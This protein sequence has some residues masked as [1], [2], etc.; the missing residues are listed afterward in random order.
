[1]ERKIVVQNITFVYTKNVDKELVKILAKKVASKI[2]LVREF[3]DG[4]IDNLELNIC[5]KTELNKIVAL[6]TSVYG[7]ENNVPQ[8]VTGF[9]SNQKVYIAMLNEKDMEY[10]SKVAVHELVHL[11]SDKIEHKERRPKLLQ[12]GIATYLSGQM[13]ENRVKKIINDY[14]NKKL[15]KLSEYINFN[16]LEFANHNGYNYSYFAMEYLVKEYGKEKI[17]YW[18]EYPADF[19]KVISELDDKF[20]KYLRGIIENNILKDD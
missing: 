10:L 15:H 14:T 4:N 3:F 19:V 7:E 1:L 9:C 17:L 5:T 6:S 11:L 12:E 8:W 16:G 2:Y 13:S 20:D 18:L